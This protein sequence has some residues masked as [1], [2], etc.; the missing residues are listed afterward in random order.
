MG[1]A[2]TMK[3]PSILKF[4]VSTSAVLLILSSG[5]RAEDAPAADD[6]ATLKDFGWLMSQQISQLDLSDSE[7][8]AFLAGIN[9]GLAGEDGPADP[10]AAAMKVQQFLQARMMAAQAKETD[11]FFAELDSNPNVKK[12]STGLYYEILEEGEEGRAGTDDTVKLHYEGSLPN[13]TVFDSS[14]QRGEPATF[15]VAG[16]VPG[17]GEGVQLVG[18]GGKVKLY[19]PPQLGYG[20]Q[21]PPGSRIP[22]NSVLVFDVEMLEVNPE[23]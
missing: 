14:K 7:Q 12:S 22:P 11:A 23:G 9:A 10:Q 15:P 19:I 17:F 4:A 16:V 20:Q 1:K 5:L 21:P 2:K 6:T 8:K 3:H 13:G 18:P